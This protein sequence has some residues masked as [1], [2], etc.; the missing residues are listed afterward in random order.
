MPL[1]LRVLPLQPLYPLLRG[2]GGLASRSGFC[3]GFAG[4]LPWAFVAGFLVAM[5]IPLLQMGIC[6]AWYAYF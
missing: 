3:A 2:G 6:L 5:K 4:A 1:R